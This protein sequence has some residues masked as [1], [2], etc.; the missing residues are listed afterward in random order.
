VVLAAAA[1]LVPEPARACA[2]CNC[3]DPTLTAVGV[4]QPYRNRV[5][6]GLEER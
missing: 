1:M 3:G 4:E 5:R 6:A 2:V